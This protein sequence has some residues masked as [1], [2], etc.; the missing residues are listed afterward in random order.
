MP[1]PPRRATAIDA[2]LRTL[3]EMIRSASHEL[4]EVRR[5]QAELFDMEAALVVAIDVRMR[6]VDDLLDQR[7][8]VHGVDGRGVPGAPASR[9]RA[10][11]CPEDRADGLPARRSGPISTTG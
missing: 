6:R 2:D 11:R 5:R 10:E 3:C 1:L 9:A 8:E 4:A 7:C